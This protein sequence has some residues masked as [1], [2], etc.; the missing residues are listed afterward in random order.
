[1]KRTLELNVWNQRAITSPAGNPF[2][3]L[4]LGKREEHNGSLFVRADNGLRLPKNVKSVKI[5]FIKGE[6]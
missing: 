3:V 6:E 4:N 2:T 5:T 1:M